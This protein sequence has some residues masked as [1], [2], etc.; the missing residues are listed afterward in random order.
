MENSPSVIY[1]ILTCQICNLQFTIQ[2][3]LIRHIKKIHQYESYKKY[4]I[5]HIYNGVYPTCKCGCGTELYFEGTNNPNFFAD[6]TTNH[7]PYNEHTVETKEKIGKSSKIT[8]LERYG[9]ENA[10]MIPKFVDKIA[11]TKL[12]KYGSHAYNNVDKMI[13]TNRET[14][15]VDYFT[16]TE[17]FKMRDKRTSK[18]ELVVSQKL[19]KELGEKL[20]G[21][22]KFKFNG[23]E[24]DF[25]IEN[26]LIEIDGDYY[27]P[28]TLSNM[29]LPHQF[30]NVVNDYLKTKSV[31]G[32]GYELVRIKSSALEGFERNLDF[33]F[34]LERRYEQDF[35][36][37]DDTVFINSQT[38]FNYLSRPTKNKTSKLLKSMQKFLKVICETDVDVPVLERIIGME[39][40]F[41][42][43]NIRLLL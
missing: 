18:I 29:N 43:K 21:E 26:Y 30:H 36:W 2:P 34:V 33:N 23:R 38:I 32:S 1:P 5:D 41:S 15:G 28:T 35:N 37:D 7:R 19:S 4:V 14:Y 27:H 25:R 24:F 12:K 17:V 9:V 8:F 6:Y 3:N 40:D 20:N 16:E 22:P 31:V 11:E 39:L 10:M 13:A 42:M